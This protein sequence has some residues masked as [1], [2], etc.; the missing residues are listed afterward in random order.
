MT[1]RENTIVADSTH[2]ESYVVGIDLARNFRKYGVELDADSLMQGLMD[3]LA[4]RRPAYEETDIRR[5]R[6]AFRNDVM[7]RVAAS[8]RALALEN[9]RQADEFLESNRAEEGVVTLPGGVQYRVLRTGDGPCPTDADSVTCEYR[10]TLLDGARFDATEAGRPATLRV[11][12]LIPGWR[13]APGA[14]DHACRLPLA[15]LHPARARLRRAGPR[16]GHQ[17]QRAADLRGGPAG[18]QLARP[19]LRSERPHP[20]S[21][22]GR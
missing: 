11:G 10:G 1:T 19:G 3:G 9:R 8:Q 17:A 22:A 21:A 14:Q 5:I 4:E 7:H 20:R 12:Q 6:V 2:S 18:D 13:Q 15:G 16:R